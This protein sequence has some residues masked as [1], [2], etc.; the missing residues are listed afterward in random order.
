M[1]K[2]EKRRQFKQQSLFPLAQGYGQTRSWA[3]IKQ[4]SK[5]KN[6]KLG[7]E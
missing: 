4:M 5:T 2:R 6:K 1:A 3:Y 7:N